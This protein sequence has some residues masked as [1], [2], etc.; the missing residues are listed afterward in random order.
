M[1]TRAFRLLCLAPLA[2]L[3]ACSGTPRATTSVSPVSPSS[4]AARLVPA[5]VIPAGRYTQ[6]FDAAREAVRGL[7]FDLERVDARQGVLSTRAKP[8]DGLATP[9]DLE[10]TTTRQE[11]EDLVNQQTRRV[12]VVFLTP[13]VRPGQPPSE[14]LDDLPP[15]QDAPMPQDLFAHTGSV[16]MRVVVTRTRTQRPGW[17]LATNSV[18]SSTFTVDPARGA[19]A[20]VAE[21]ESPAGEDKDLA[22][23]VVEQVR[24]ALD[25]PKLKPITTRRRA[26]TASN[27]ADPSKL[28]PNMP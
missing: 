16:T 3:A 1:M 11:L 17:R 19:T 9:W 7:R 28:P 21:Y 22:L 18:R 5:I 4:T 23:R 15:L 14:E 25:L 10:Q 26:A 12:R 6:A 27:P 2:A 20:E 8:S 24:V 13:V